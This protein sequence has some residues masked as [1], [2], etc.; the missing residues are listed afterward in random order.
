MPRSQSISRDEIIARAMFHF[1]SKGYFASSMSE[2]VAATGAC[3]HAFY[4]EFKNKKALFLAC[5]DHY[6]PLV[7]SPAFDQVEKKEANLDSV[8]HYFEFQISRAESLSGFPG[9]GC[10]VANTMAEVIQQDLE[11][12]ERIDNHLSRLEKGFLIALK[13]ENSTQKYRSIPELRALAGLMTTMTQGIW[14][15]SRLVDSP[16]PIRSSV[17][18]LIDLVKLKIETP[19]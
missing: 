13:N 6:Q 5:L 3:R 15:Q 17:R 12:R 10:L 11:V 7:V 14:S 1:W 9:P 2:L 18:C 4:R 8:N 16:K 19:V